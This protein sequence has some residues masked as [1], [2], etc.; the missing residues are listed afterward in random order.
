[1]RKY[2]LDNIKWFVIVLVLVN[3]VVSIFSS[4]GSL[5]SYNAKGIASMDAIGYFIYP[6]FMPILFVIAGISA[7]YSLQH[8][9]AKE[10]RKERVWKLLIPFLAYLFLIGP[11]AGE[12][13][14]KVNDYENV[15]AA[16]PDFVIVI[17]K[18]LNGM[19][20]SWFLLQLFLLSY[21]LLLVRRLDKKEK[22]F[23]LGKQCNLRMLLLLYFPVLLAAQILYVAFTFRNGLYLLLFLLGYYMFSEERVQNLLEKWNAYFLLVGFLAGILQCYVSWGKPYQEVVNHWLVMLYTWFMILGVMGCAGRWFNQNNKLTRYMRQ[24]SFGLY[25][26]HYVPMVY[27]AYYLTTNFKLPDIVNYIVVLIL[28]FAASIIL[29]EILVRIPVVNLIL[30]LKK[31][32]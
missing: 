6:W 7:R 2:Y 19:G 1:M 26:F 32:N 13:A 3:H 15:F 17:I 27:I 18:L 16:L 23:W 12:L 14:F 28:S 24:R 20:P 31:K 21:V 25:L 22:L 11:L 10:F 4:N 5:M 9:S 29:F 30:G 8:R